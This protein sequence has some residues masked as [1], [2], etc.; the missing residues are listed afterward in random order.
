GKA[1]ME[2]IDAYNSSRWDAIQPG[3][4]NLKPYEQ[5]GTADFMSLVESLKTMVDNGN[6][7]EEVVD[8]LLE[9][10]KYK[11]YILGE[12]EEEESSRMENIETLKFVLGRYDNVKDFL[13]YIELM[14]SKAKHSI[15]G[16]QL[17]TIHKSKGLEFPV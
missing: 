3:L 4:L 9:E 17:M 14:T 6:T 2:K 10:G 7:P 16:V 11:E 8:H 1:F 5:R 15:D 12:E 13:D